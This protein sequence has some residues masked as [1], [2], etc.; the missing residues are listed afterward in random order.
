[1]NS[2]ISFF[3][4]DCEMSSKRKK[5]AFIIRIEI[6]ILKKKVNEKVKLKYNV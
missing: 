6:L 1:M 2:K 4:I 3:V 5:D